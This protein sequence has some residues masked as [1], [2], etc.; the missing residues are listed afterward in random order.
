MVYHKMLVGVVCYAFIAFT[1]VALSG[2]SSISGA[3]KTPRFQYRLI[4]LGK[5]DINSVPLAPFLSPL[6][7][8]HG[9][10]IGN[11]SKGGFLRDPEIG[12]WAPN[13]N[14]VTIYF[15]AISNNGDILV[16]LNRNQHTTDW[17][18]WPTTKGKNG[19]RQRINLE[20]DPDSKLVFT[21]L[22]NDRMV[23]GNLFKDGKSRPIFWKDEELNFL[24]D[25]EG[26]SIE[27]LIKGVNNSSQITG[28]FLHAN[29]MPPGV[30]SSGLGLKRLRNF[31]SKPTPDS[32]AELVELLI[33]EDGTVYGTYNVKY[34]DPLK[35]EKLIA[36]AWFPYEEGG[37]KLLDLD[38]MHMVALNQKHTLVGSLNGRAAI[39]E[40]GE[41]P[42][43]LS[44][45]IPSHELKNWELL[46]VSSINN[47]GDL[48]G[49]GKFK[50]N[51]HHF[52]AKKENRNSDLSIVE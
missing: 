39:C 47:Q 19:P 49:Y 14:G 23:I 10:I 4:D 1:T 8:N 5:A 11:R 3:P 26:K 33:A 2:Q 45:I 42:I 36:Y 52:F 34:K 13:I 48:V 46:G 50:G 29:D 17:M 22:T 21:D 7:N 12:E 41:R 35:Q 44:K 37:F 27:G 43:E 16:S 9:Q 51:M 40:P 18:I 30:W 6:I 15:H 28:F 24:S 20:V 31:R 25:S 32:Q 38:G